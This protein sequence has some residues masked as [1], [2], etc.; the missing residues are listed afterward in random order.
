MPVRIA[1]G[2]ATALDI[3]ASLVVL[4]AT[5]F[6]VIRFGA[7]LYRRGIVHTGRRLRLSEAL[8]SP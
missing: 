7:A 1:L 3:V 4:I 2:D 5:V 8:R 6:V